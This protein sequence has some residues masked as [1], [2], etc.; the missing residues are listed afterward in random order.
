MA[1]EFKRNK[2]NVK[3]GSGDFVEIPVLGEQKTEKATVG[4]L[5][6]EVSRATAAEEAIAAR[7]DKLQKVV[8]SPFV[9]ATAASMTNT[10]RVYVY[11]GS[12]T[13]YTAGNWYYYDGTAWVSGGVYNSAGVNVDDTLTYEGMAAD[14]KATGDEISNVKNAL[15][16]VQVALK[17]PTDIAWELG[18]IDLAGAETPSSSRARTVGYVDIDATISIDS[19]IGFYSYRFYDSNDSF[20]ESTDWMTADSIPEDI[21][22]KSAS[23][24]CRLV[25]KNTT[26]TQ[27]TA[28]TA[29]QSVTILTIQNPFDKIDEISGSLYSNYDLTWELGH[30]NPSGQ[31]VSASNRIREVEFLPFDVLTKITVDND[32]KYVIRTYSSNGTFLKGTGWLTGNGTV[33]EKYRADQTPTGTEVTYRIGLAYTNDSTVTSV[34]DLSSKI[35]LTAEYTLRD[36]LDMVLDESEQSNEITVNTSGLGNASI[37]CAKE[38]SYVDGSAPQ[39]EYFL[40]EEP[41]THKFY[42]SK[43]LATKRYMFTFVGDSY[44]YSFGVLQ[45][46]DVIACLDADAITSET[47]N[48][49]NRQNPFVFLASENWSVQHEV[50]FGTSLKPCG[51][52]ENC[53]FKVLADGSAIFCEYTRQTTATANAWKLSGDPTD[54]TSW[55]VTQSFAITTTDNSNNFKHCHCVMQDFYTGTCYLATGDSDK[56]AMLFASADNG[57]TWTQLLS[58]DSAEHDHETGFAGGSEKYC[59]ML[60]MTF[61]KDFIYWA[62]DTA[63]AVN[64][65]LFKA[66]R[67]INGVLDYSTVEEVVNIPFANYAA[68]YGTAYIPELNAILLLERTDNAET[69]MPVRLVTLT[70]SVL[71]TIGKMEVTPSLASGANL[72]FRTRFSEWYPYNGLVRVGYDLHMQTHNNAVNQNKGFGNEGHTTTGNG[73]LNINNLFLQIYRNGNEYGFHLGT[74]YV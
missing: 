66:E 13:G 28:Q 37:R 8:G 17:Y 18:N 56:G 49:T 47:K 29:K 20:T 9:A 38:Q 53:G 74:Y 24:K 48:D 55:R 57:E 43:D 59:R 27:I 3:D 67:D 54:V 71:H 60:S 46:G 62:S 30:I 1:L 68:T 5:A 4:E 36:L 14:A 34:S 11:T 64:H 25:F 16:E 6:I 70:D 32:V 22:T 45:N 72:G 31:D 35:T 61:T 73:S 33:Y 15:S 52:L 23:T 69:E 41:L 2:L 40:L 26:G 51:W 10:D 21:K 42:M 58:P 7:V 63:V 50:D 12:E 19:S 44:K 39:I 65:F